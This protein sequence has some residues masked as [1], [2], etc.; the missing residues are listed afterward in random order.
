MEGRR[1]RVNIGNISIE[2]TTT[3]FGQLWLFIV[4]PLAGAVLGAL[5][6]RLGLLR[7]TRP[8]AVV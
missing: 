4:T 5:P 7:V 8:A 6:F 3:G 2:T 1:T